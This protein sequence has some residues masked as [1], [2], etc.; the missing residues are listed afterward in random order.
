MECLNSPPEVSAL[1]LLDEIVEYIAGTAIKGIPLAF[2]LVNLYFRMQSYHWYNIFTLWWRRNELVSHSLFLNLDVFPSLRTSAS[3]QLLGKKELFVDLLEIEMHYTKEV[4]FTFIFDLFYNEKYFTSRIRNTFWFINKSREYTNERLFSL[5]LSKY[6]IMSKEI[7]P[8]M[9]RLIYPFVDVTDSDKIR[10]LRRYGD[11]IKVETTE[12]GL[13]VMRHIQKRK[14]KELISIYEEVFG[15][16]RNQIVKNIVALKAGRTPLAVSMFQL[17]NLSIVP[18][19][20]NVE[21]TIPIL[22]NKLNGQLKNYIYKD[23]KL[24]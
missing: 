3:I 7:K 9:I 1:L 14:A 12:D 4:I 20:S 10:Y 8:E 19:I 18:V 23:S 24:W 13:N 16:Y 22:I 15:V 17:L 21:M 5:L 11:R 2:I 6:E